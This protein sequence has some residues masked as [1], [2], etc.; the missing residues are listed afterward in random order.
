MM[1]Y[2]STGRYARPV[3]ATASMAQQG[4]CDARRSNLRAN[5]LDVLKREGYIRGY[6]PGRAAA[7]HG[8]V[9]RSS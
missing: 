5:V 8:A 1:M 6:S 9:R 3:S 4:Q 2:R 7:R